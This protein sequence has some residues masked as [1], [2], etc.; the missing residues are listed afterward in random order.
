VADTADPAEKRADVLSSAIK[1]LALLD[2]LA[3][4]SEPLTL[5]VLA[6]LTGGLK[7]TVYK[8]MRTLI[9]AGWAEQLPDARYRLT[10]HAAEVGNAVLEQADL[11]SRILPCLASLATSSGETASLAVL[12]RGSALVVQRVEADRSIKVDIKPGTRMPLDQSASGRVLLAFGPPDVIA[13]LRNRDMTKLSEGA[14]QAIRREG[15]ACSVDEYLSGM[16]SIAV[17][18]AHP[19]QQVAALALMTPT[20]RYSTERLQPQLAAAADKLSVLLS[21]RLAPSLVGR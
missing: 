18:V 4:G 13:E 8:Q 3:T 10:L 11:G 16:A 5:G 19:Q 15:Y 1:C 20:D 6:E 17:P 2:A 14:S 7:S 12:D 9:V 21:G